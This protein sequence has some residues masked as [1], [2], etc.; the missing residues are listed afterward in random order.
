MLICLVIAVLNAVLVSAESEPVEVHEWG[1]VVF[2]EYR[3]AVAAV[4]DA[5]LSSFIADP[6]YGIEPISVEAPVIFFHGAEFRGDFV[7]EVFNGGIF[8]VFPVDGMTSEWNSI[9]WSGIQV[10]EPGEGTE[11]PEALTADFL[12]PGEAVQNWRTLECNSVRTSGGINEGFLYY[13]CYLETPDFMKYPLLL[14]E[15]EGLPEGVDKVL[16]FLKPYDDMQEM[17][18]VYPTSIYIPLET[19]ESSVYDR[20][21]ML[22]ILSSWNT[23]GLYSDELELL[24]DTWEA[25]VTDPLWEGDALVVFPLPQEMID[26][27]S[28]LEVL[29][30]G[31]MEITYGRFFIGMIP[32]SWWN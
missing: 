24:W 10:F 3:A 15:G 17:Y 5:G 29:P 9:K 14:V 31:E 4:P 8:E 11:Y 32:V 28:S 19:E 20:E 12:L 18:L 6:Y 7:V 16:I 25:Y 1:V 23:S 27:I 2:G 22:E 30:D 26:K 21:E 13:E